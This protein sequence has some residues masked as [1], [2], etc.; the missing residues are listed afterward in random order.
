MKDSPK[1]LK[2]KNM[3]KKELDRHLRIL[4][5]LIIIQMLNVVGCVDG[6]AEILE[7]VMKMSAD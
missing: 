1:S 6:S 3:K 2:F 4:T 7:F 5:A